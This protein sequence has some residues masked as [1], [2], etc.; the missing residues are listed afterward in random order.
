[1][2]DAA[3]MRPPVH[4]LPTDHRELAGKHEAD[5]TSRQPPA[6]TIRAR[7]FTLVAV[8]KFR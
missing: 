7:I 3:E 4:P 6:L 1:M 2:N 5:E 8:R